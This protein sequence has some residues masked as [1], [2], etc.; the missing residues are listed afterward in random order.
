M[1][2]VVGEADAECADTGVGRSHVRDLAVFQVE[3]RDLRAVAERDVRRPPVDRALRAERSMPEL[4][5]FDG[6]SDIVVNEVPAVLRARQQIQTI[7]ASDGDQ[8]N[9]LADD[10][11]GVLFEAVLLDRNEA[12]QVLVHHV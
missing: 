10:R 2:D 3:N 5:R 1:T 6:S 8:I 11:I 7:E 12:A 9:A 4:A